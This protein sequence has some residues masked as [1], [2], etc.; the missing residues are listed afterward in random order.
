MA[1][2]GDLTRRGDPSGCAP[3]DL[4]PPRHS[5]DEGLWA[6]TSY[7][8]PMRY[9]RRRANYRAFRE[10][11][12]APLVA[13]ELAHGR[14]CELTEEDADVLIQ[15][16][17]GDVMWQK[18][19]LLNVA[20]GGLPTSCRKVVW[21]DCD[22]VFATEDW[23]ER[24]SA[25]LERFMLVQAFSHV[26]H[27]SPEATSTDT[28]GEIVCTQ[29][30][31][32]LAIASGMRGTNQFGRPTLRGPGSTNNGLAWAARRELL[33]E[34]GFY[35][36]CIV[37]GGDLAM[38]SAAHGRFDVA[39]RSMSA[40]QVDHYLDWARPY[41]EMVGAET[42]FSDGLVSHLW[43]GDIENRRYRGRHDG[44]K[45]F[46]FDPLDDITQT[47]DGGWRW[48]TAKPGLHAYVRSYFVARN[49][50]G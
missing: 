17:D 39:T 18:E 38:I 27:L 9:R 20:L 29:P 49:E 47:A 44:L 36:A 8:N 42:S 28:H 24:V 26:H 34:V 22:I 37:G 41:H 21:A 15:L 46:G 50:D 25:L 40:R 45:R 16:R 48:N 5:G 30:S 33:D 12:N 11:L 19:R 3:S 2:E 4:G 7:F 14:D 1:C 23:A 32:A 31:A 35:D 6:L 43:H 13:V 10:R